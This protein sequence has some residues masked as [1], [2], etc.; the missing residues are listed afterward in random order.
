MKKIIEENPGPIDLHLKNLGYYNNKL[1]LLD[2]GI[3]LPW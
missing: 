3:I 2:F 1:V